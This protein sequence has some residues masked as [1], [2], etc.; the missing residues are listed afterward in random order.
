MPVAGF[1]LV[2]GRSSRMGRDKARLPLERHLL[3]EEV[4]AK[5]SC[6]AE[7]VALV[8]NARLYSDLKIQCLND[9]RSGC[10]PLAGI[11]TALKSG[12]GD[13]SLIV[14]CDMPG[15]QLEWLAQLVATASQQESG[16]IV[17]RDKAGIVHPLCSVW[18]PN[19]LPQVER[20]LDAG[21]WRL[22]ELIGALDAVCVSVAET[23]PNVNT[24]EEWRAWQA[25]EFRE[26]AS[27]S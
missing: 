14:A 18:K 12:R 6:I 19:C 26:A 27:F 16:C 7:N 10:G 1:V 17:C 11:E 20:A 24:P 25:R 22:M 13:L 15:L 9:L 3:V 23:I 4:A 2:G 8:G 5:V 21:R